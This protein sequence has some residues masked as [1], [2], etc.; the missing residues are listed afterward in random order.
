[1]FLLALKG[2]KGTSPGRYGFGEQRYYW[3]VAVP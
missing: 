2:L 1:M 3:I